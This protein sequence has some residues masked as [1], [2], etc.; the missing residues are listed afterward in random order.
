VPLSGR[1]IHVCHYLPLSVAHASSAGAAPPSPP[2]TPQ[3]KEQSLVADA[4]A[5][6]KDAVA[7][8]A[9]TLTSAATT[10]EAEGKPKSKWALAPRLGHS[11][12]ISGILSL[13]ATHEQVIV[14]WTGDIGAPGGTPESP[15]SV[16]GFTTTT[17]TTG[18]C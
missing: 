7:A 5:S 1:V 2:L 3:H 14:G 12:M 11:A 10:T 17:T 18:P 9:S 6:A 4:L 16:S 15:A 8:A 13:S